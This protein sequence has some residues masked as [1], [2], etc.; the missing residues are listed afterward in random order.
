MLREVSLHPN[1]LKSF[2]NRIVVRM[3]TSCPVFLHLLSFPVSRDAKCINC[4][5]SLGLFELLLLLKHSLNVTGHE[6]KRH[7]TKLHE[8]DI[9]IFRVRLPIP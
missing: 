1:H 5:G 8:I 9:H 4:L 2:F 6:K 7:E 3:P